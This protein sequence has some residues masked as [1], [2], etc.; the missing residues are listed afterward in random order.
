[1]L[2]LVAQSE[3]PVTRKELVDQSGLDRSTLARILKTLES[4][5]MISFDSEAKTYTVGIK[6]LSWAGAFMR[7]NDLRQT[8]APILRQLREAS[9]ET[10]TL[11][12]RSG[13]DRVCIDGVE[14][15]DEIR[16]VVV[17]GER[18]PLWQGTTSK[19]ILAQLSAEEV[20]EIEERASAE[21]AS[22][23]GIDDQLAAAREHG[24]LTLAEDRVPGVG[25][26]SAP[27]FEAG[28]VVGA[29]SVAGPANRWTDER[30]EEIAPLLVRLAGCVSASISHAN[31]ATTKSVL[32]ASANHQPAAKGSA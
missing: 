18:V 20:A 31:P 15:P 12:I 11:H 8:A 21:G 17:L 14:S 5:R 24:Y 22:L 2:D 27:I 29:F 9:N 28:V 1:V 19:V 25:S 26:I 32:A 4:T 7:G 13:F 10:A 23:N 16:R 6:L 30:C 3:G